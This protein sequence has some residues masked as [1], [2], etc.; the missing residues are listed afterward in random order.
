[1]GVSTG[2][3]SL[4]EDPAFDA[5]VRAPLIEGQALLLISGG[6]DGAPC[7][8][9]LEDDRMTNEE[10]VRTVTILQDRQ[11]IHDCLMRYSR[12]VDRLDRELLLSV[13]HEDAIDDHGVFV[14]NPRQFADWVVAMHTKTHLSHQHCIFN[15]SVD[16][17]GDTAHVESYYMF[18]GLNRTGT[19]LAMSGG[20][21]LDR[22]E[23]RNGR[24][25]IAARLCVR[26]WAPLAEVPKQLDQ[27]AL[28]VVKLDERTTHLMRSGAQVARDKTDPSYARPLTI[29]PERLKI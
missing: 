29:D 18:V 10:L 6:R 2:A 27:A 24:W 14:G 7:S 12:G 3:G 25:A 4:V 17:Q 28:T 11:A 19:P 1:M 5:T 15:T 9:S 20:R 26:D 8:Q 16:L 22:F 13:Y 23:K 21:Y